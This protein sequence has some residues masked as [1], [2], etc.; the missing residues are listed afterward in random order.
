ME[1]A[2]DRCMCTLSDLF[3]VC[4]EPEEQLKDKRSMKFIKDKVQ[5]MNEAQPPLKLSDY[6]S[7][8]LIIINKVSKTS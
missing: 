6:P 4:H 1:E 7:S 8:L 2:E 3:L 5:S